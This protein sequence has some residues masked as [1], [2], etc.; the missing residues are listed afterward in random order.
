[1]ECRDVQLL[2]QWATHW[3]DLVDFEFVPGRRSQQA[4][5]TITPEL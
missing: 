4:V 3:Q 5:A 2:N 1:M